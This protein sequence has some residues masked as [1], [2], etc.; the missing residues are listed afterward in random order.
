MT[1]GSALVASQVS[2]GDKTGPAAVGMLRVRIGGND[3]VVA[4]EAA[5]SWLASF[6]ECQVRSE[7]LDF[8]SLVAD[9]PDEQHGR[10][11]VRLP[12]RKFKQQC[13]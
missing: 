3:P 7:A 2:Q 9:R 1:M 5:P 12:V 6:A 8:G 10:R 13:T 4:G 11:A